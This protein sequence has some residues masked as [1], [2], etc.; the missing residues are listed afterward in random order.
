MNCEYSVFTAGLSL[1][2]VQPEKSLHAN[3]T[4]CGFDPSVRKRYA[5][6]GR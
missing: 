1:V 2:I 5:P 3:Y 6:Y 4:S